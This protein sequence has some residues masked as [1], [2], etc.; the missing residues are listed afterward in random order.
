MEYWAEQRDIGNE[1]VVI[2]AAGINL[3]E[4]RRLEPGA[5]ILGHLAQDRRRP[6]S[7]AARR[8]A[9]L[10]ELALNRRA[11]GWMARGA[12]MSR[13]EILEF[14]KQAIADTLDTL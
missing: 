1:F 3:V 8:D 7:S 12:G 6:A 5:V 4:L 10:G 2:E 14:T 13:A 11:E 9:A